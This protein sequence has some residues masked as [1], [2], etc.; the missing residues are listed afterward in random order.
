[1]RQVHAR[2]RH[3]HARPDWRGRPGHAQGRR[4]GRARPRLR[5]V[6][7]GRA[8]LRPPPGQ[9]GPGPARVREP[10]VSALA[11]RRLAVA[12]AAGVVLAGAAW[13]TGARA[14]SEGGGQATGGEVATTTA[15]V[16][17]RDL[18]AQEEVDGTLGYGEAR[19]VGNQRDG[20]ITGL[21]AGGGAAATGGRA[22]HRVDDK[23][24]P[25]FYGPLPAWRAL[26]VG[27]GDGPDVRQ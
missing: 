5:E 24:V 7:A 8:G 9:P 17:R 20:T 15:E 18:R 14:G 19:L 21:P 13:W 23:P 12:A 27:V 11:P 2:A 26:S 6:P 10:V 25:L 22:L 4:Q 16:T 3:R 1:L